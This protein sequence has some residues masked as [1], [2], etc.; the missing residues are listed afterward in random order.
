[1]SLA[2]RRNT[3]ARA[4]WVRRWTVLRSVLR[5]SRS[6]LESQS[7]CPRLANGAP[8]AGDTLGL[9]GSALALLGDDVVGDGELGEGLS[10]DVGIVAPVS[11]TVPMSPRSPLV[12]TSSRVGASTTV[13]IGPVDGQPDRGPVSIGKDRPLP[14][15][16]RSVSGILARSLATSWAFV[17]VP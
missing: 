15:E 13:A 12:L 3:T 2:E 11:Q 17:H 5:R 1:M 16:L 8:S 10:S 7:W 14:A 6:K 9:A 4:N